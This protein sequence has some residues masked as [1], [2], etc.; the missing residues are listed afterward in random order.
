MHTR[1]AAA[2]LL[3]LAATLTA[4]TTT[5]PAP[6]KPAAA[7]STPAPSHAELIQQCTDAV[8]NLPVG[9]D[10]EVPS[11]PVPAECTGLSDSDYLDAYMDGIN[12][13]NQDALNAR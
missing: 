10:G 6:D 12:Q 8:A 11:D 9:E 7:T 2:T 5:D 13:A 1:T 3:V 4:C